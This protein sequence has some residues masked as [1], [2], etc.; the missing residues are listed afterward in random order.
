[1]K[2]AIHYIDKKCDKELEKN[3]MGQPEILE[4]T[5]KQV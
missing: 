3:H 5:H 4:E 2:K 1:M